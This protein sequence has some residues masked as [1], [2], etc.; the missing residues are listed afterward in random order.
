MVNLGSNNCL[1]QKSTQKIFYPI[2]L[3]LTGIEKLAS[4]KSHQLEILLL[5]PQH[6]SWKKKQKQKKAK[7]YGLSKN[8]FSKGARKTIYFLYFH[9]KACDS[10]SQMFMTF[11]NWIRTQKNSHVLQDKVFDTQALRLAASSRVFAMFP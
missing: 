6:R 9:I 7:N 10:I 2:C 1:P 4:Q 11:S 3:F 8:D 5:F